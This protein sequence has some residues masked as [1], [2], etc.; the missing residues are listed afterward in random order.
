MEEVVCGANSR[1]GNPPVCPVC[2]RPGK[3]VAPKTL[4]GILKSDRLPAA[5]EGYGLCLS[6]ECDAVYFGPR[7]FFKDDVRVRVWFKEDDPSVPVCYC[8]HVT[9]ADILDHVA[10]RRCCDNLAD[11]QQHTGANTG[12]D[13][14]TMNPAGT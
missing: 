3:R 1:D 10:V 4:A 13:C 5:L 9:A 8:R 14:L 11:I 2:H 6:P 12:R 7:V